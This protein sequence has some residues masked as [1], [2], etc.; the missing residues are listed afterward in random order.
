LAVITSRPKNAIGLVGD[1]I[2]L[3]CAADNAVIWQHDNT[4]I[5]GPGCSNNTYATTPGSNSTHCSVIVH[6][7]DPV[8]LS[9]VYRCIA[10]PDDALAI[11]IIVGQYAILNVLAI[12]SQSSVDRSPW[13]FAQWS[14]IS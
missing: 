6:G 10:P 12:G 7:N 1:K 3:E 2:I 9:G 14:L 8:R 4:G 11:A 5:T 13:N